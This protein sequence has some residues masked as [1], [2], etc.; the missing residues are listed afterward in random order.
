MD[1]LPRS[2]SRPRV[3]IVGTEA[4]NLRL[5]LMD[6]LVSHGFDPCAAGALPQPE[7]DDTPYDYHQYPVCRS[8]S[9]RGFQQS[10]A[11][12]REVIQQAQP[13]LVHAVNT[14]PCLI[15]PRATRSLGIPCVRTV[16]GLGSAFS[17]EGLLYRGMQLAFRHMH[18]RVADDVLMTVFQNPDDLDYF[19]ETGLCPADQ[20][21]LIL[22]SGIDI[23]EFLS[24]ISSPKRLDEIR[25]ELGLHGRTVITMVSRM[26][27][28]KG[29]AELVEAAEAVHRRHPEALVLLVGPLVESGP[30]ALSEAAISSSDA[31]KWIGLRTDVADILSVSDAFVLPSYLREGI[32]RVL[33]EA[34]ALKLPIVTT[35]MP[36]CRETV[37][38]GWNGFLIP[39]RDSKAIERALESLLESPEQR[40]E[41]GRNSLELVR[42]RFELSIVSQAYADVYRDALGLSV[43]R[44]LVRA[45]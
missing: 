3:L 13:D 33:F 18:R 12:L 17:S 22:G 25:T 19:V 16:T 15:A 29:V 6:Q 20:T 40:R 32:P 24:R 30:S 4:L 41:M 44:R 43:D 21:K 37:R 1:G 39:P 11:A 31:V 2:D 36:G 42:D 26:M 7:F 14:K 23:D 8:V 38:D 10:V 45:A 9:L 27:R 35:D 5:P 28:T 34:G